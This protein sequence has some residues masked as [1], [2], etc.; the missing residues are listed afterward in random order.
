MLT[1]LA[2]A[3]VVLAFLLWP[4]PGSVVWSGQALR[5]VMQ[6]ASGPSVAVPES[7]GDAAPRRRALRVPGMASLSRLSQRR[8][9]RV[10]DDQVVTLLDALA[11]G[12]G[13]GLTP[14]AALQASISADRDGSQL[15]AVVP[16]LHAAER[17][18]PVGPA[19][20][21]VA[22]RTGHPDLAA[23]AR[24]WGL[25][26]RLGCPLSE[27]VRSAAASSR[28]RTQLRQRLESA[29]A[30]TRATSVLLTLLPLSG[31]GVAPLLGLTLGELYGTT[32]GATSLAAGVALLLLGR[33]TVE[34]MVQGVV[35][36]S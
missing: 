24:A 35:S 19:W 8:R 30:G 36:A 29:T 9:G 28:S 20:E 31:V 6:V 5:G 16:V 23:L 32:A 33:W 13:A 21:R 15:R 2:A 12:L 11:A 25:S 14:L 27:A 17:G 34:R 26:E 10:I 22:R 4:G 7:A 1:A 3:L 18:G